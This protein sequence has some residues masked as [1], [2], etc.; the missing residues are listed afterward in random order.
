MVTTKHHTLQPVQN[1]EHVANQQHPTKGV[2]YCCE[3]T[4]PP[5][6]IAPENPTPLSH[7]HDIRHDAH[8]MRTS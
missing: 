7:V 8:D 6:S 3:S 4:I 5:L 1:T 2:S